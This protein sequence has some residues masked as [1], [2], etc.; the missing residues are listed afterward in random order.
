MR[1][2]ALIGVAGRMNSGKTT[3]ARYL[4]EKHQCIPYALADNVRVAL[5]T[6]NPIIAL[7]GRTVEDVIEAEEDWQKVKSDPVLGP[8]I[9]QLLQRLGTDVGRKMFGTSVWLFAAETQLDATLPDW[10]RENRGP[11][12]VVHDIRFSNEAKW[13]HMNRGTVINVVRPSLI[14]GPRSGH[15][16]EQG[17]DP[18]LA[19][20][21]ILNVG[22]LDEL[23]GQVDDIYRQEFGYVRTA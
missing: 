5:R 9:R 18:S 3:I 10:W 4:A 14:P 11:Q 6:L 13:V 8:E 17:I 15:E 7:D 12:I 21:T 23:Y 19:D 16:S 22:S 2:S 20:Y 1:T